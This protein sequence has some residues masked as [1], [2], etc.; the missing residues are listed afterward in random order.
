MRKL[1]A[2]L[3]LGMLLLPQVAGATTYHVY[4]TANNVSP[5]FSTVD[6]AIDAVNVGSGGDT[7]SIDDS[8]T[9]T[10]AGTKY[11]YA[12]QTSIVAA[13]GQAPTLKI[14]AAG[15]GNL[16]YILG[17]G[18]RV[19]SNAGG[20]ITFDGQGT[21][22]R[23]INLNNIWNPTPTQVAA[24]A[25]PWNVAST[26]TLENLV[27]KNLGT[28]VANT[29][30]YP[31]WLL[32][33]DSTTTAPL[34]TTVILR[35]IDFQIPAGL[36]SVNPSAANNYT[37][38]R[39][40]LTSGAVMT[41]ENCRCNTIQG[42]VV[43]CGFEGS[44]YSTQW[45]TLNL[46][47]CRFAYTD[48]TMINGARMG[49]PVATMGFGTPHPNGFVINV[50]NCYLRNDAPNA[51]YID[52]TRWSRTS[53]D[54]LN[55]FGAISLMDQS[56]NVLNVT[57]SAII[58]CGSGINID[59]PQSA[60]TLVNSDIYVPTVAAYTRGN[61][62]NVCPRTACATGNHQTTATRCNFFGINGS[63]IQAGR[64]AAGSTFKMVQCNDW[65]TSN[66]Y[67][68][69][70]VLSNCVQPGK[71]PGYGAMDGSGDPTAAINAY[72]LT[73]YNQS[74]KALNIGSDRAFLMGVPVELST[75]TLQ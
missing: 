14:P 31:L 58:G 57:N 5:N 2:M 4:A 9:Y 16:W 35:D 7:I 21:S 37:V 60:V 68:T 49:C 29:N 40:H 52:G 59:C 54:N 32:T 15:S 36:P 45:G 33:A 42:Y 23:G 24:G 56:K 66:A 71:N 22:N 43:T 12:P 6:A 13:A 25:K 61:F 26:T 62:V 73:V 75:F 69:D 63:N 74:V 44:N 47:N 30:N 3:C 41:L 34:G 38:V 64:R 72:D 28:N 48:P 67:A 55:A 51:N 11:I 18:C 39:A 20:T 53:P 27:F 17:Y 65:S 10:T 1:Q 50:D 19:G 8:A 70:W 46:K